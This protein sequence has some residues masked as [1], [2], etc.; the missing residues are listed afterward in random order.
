VPAAFTIRRVGQWRQ[1]AVTL[2]RMTQHRLQEALDIAM[3][4]EAQRARELLVRGVQSSAPGGRRFAPLADSTLLVRRALG[5]RGAGAT[6]PLVK[7]G[8]LLRAFTVR[9][10]KGEGAFAGILRSARSRNGQNLV[11]LMEVH[12][13]GKT[14]AIKVTPAM[15]NFLMAMF[16]SAGTAN[17]NAGGG[18][19]VR[20]V[21]VVRIPAR[22][23]FQPVFERYFKP[24]DV[25]KR[26]NRRLAPLLLLGNGGGG[27]P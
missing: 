15:R 17:P 5:G 23:V 13:R 4:E 1:A 8:G 25:Q 18:G 10:R 20:G 14:I 11:N 3:L 7:T 24:S 16:R 26:V 27:V 6:K 12:E 19:L 9:Q 21:I 2:S 22:P